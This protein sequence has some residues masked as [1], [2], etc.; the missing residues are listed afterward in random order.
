M[1]R[2]HLH[3]RTG[4]GIRFPDRR[5][6]V[7]AETRSRRPGC[8]AQAVVGRGVRRR[9]EHAERGHGDTRYALNSAIRFVMFCIELLLSLRKIRC[10]DPS[11]CLRHR[12]R[13]A[14]CP[15]DRMSNRYSFQV[16]PECPAP[17]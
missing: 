2:C 5:C 6:P 12:K 11:G 3:D 13:C 17:E 14:A 7:L 4:P 16:R 15:L 1:S 9:A 10:P 8:Q